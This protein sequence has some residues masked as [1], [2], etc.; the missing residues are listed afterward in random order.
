MLGGSWDVGK[1]SLTTW[2]NT[3]TLTRPILSQYQWFY[4]PAWE[5]AKKLAEE[6]RVARYG[7]RNKRNQSKKAGIRQYSTSTK[8]PANE[9]CNGL[10][11]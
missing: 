11:R 2:I 3:S 7:Q 8:A 10:T 1:E 5:N 4:D 6:T 9:V